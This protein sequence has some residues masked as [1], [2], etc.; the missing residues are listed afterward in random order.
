MRAAG[1]PAFRKLYGRITRPEGLAPGTYTVRVSNGAENAVDGTFENAH[2]GG[3]QQRF[4][5]PV[6]TFGGT[7]AVVLST[8][9]WIGGRNLFLG[10]A[11]VVVG[12][13]SIVLALCFLLKYR[14]SPRELGD[15]SYITWQSSKEKPL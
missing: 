8:T 7:K 10:Y 4:L 3:E 11:Y 12:V 14:L 9:S 6:S 1:L 13:I 15:A 2:S 5:Y